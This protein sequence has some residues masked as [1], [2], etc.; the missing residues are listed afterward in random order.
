[1]HPNLEALIAEIN[2]LLDRERDEIAITR[3]VAELLKKHVLSEN[4]IPEPYTRPNPHKYMLY[5]LYIAPDQRFS[6]A[7]A[8]WDVGQST[9]I[10]DHCTWGV[11]ALTRGEEVE[12]HYEISDGEAPRKKRENRLKKGEVAVCCTSEHDI[13]K[14]SC[15]SD[16]PCIGIHVYGAN[17]GQ[18][19]RHVYDPAT[20]NRK[21]VVTA[22]DPVPQG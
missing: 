17:I 13:H 21:T 5:P 20:G 11:I 10:H 8:V 15:A 16:I 14:V 18:I 2:G 9:P 6:I 19:E 4:V 7:S 1:M 3:E 22:W 12:I